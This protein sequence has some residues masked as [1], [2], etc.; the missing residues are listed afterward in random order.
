[1]ANKNL[2]NMTE[3]FDQK[4]CLIEDYEEES[5]DSESETVTDDED[6]TKNTT[7][8]GAKILKRQFK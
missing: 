5:S 2:V 3:F 6:K 4:I 8:K 1:M 7:L